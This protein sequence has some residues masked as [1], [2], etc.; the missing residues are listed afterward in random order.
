MIKKPLNSNVFE[1]AKSIT[2][3][4]K[5]LSSLSFLRSTLPLLLS[6]MS[7]LVVTGCGFK[8]RGQLSG[9]LQNKQIVVDAENYYHPLAVE[10][11]RRLQI[12]GAGVKKPGSISEH[13]PEQSGPEAQSSESPANKTLYVFL[14]DPLEQTQTL[15]VD[16]D[17]RPLEYELSLQVN[18]K[19]S[20]LGNSSTGSTGQIENL[21]EPV[22]MR[23]RR[24]LVYDKEQ[25]LAKSRERQ[26]ILEE[27][28]RALIEQV[29]ERL[30]IFASRN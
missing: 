17:G 18:A 5:S 14:S 23:V 8:L 3:N 9:D 10:L 27:M 26:Q 1:T 16:I 20:M 25:L 11:R 15:S 19:I 29:A 4:A 21:E 6:L 13:R 22:S 12:L 30:R 7:L 2:N 28:N 24:V